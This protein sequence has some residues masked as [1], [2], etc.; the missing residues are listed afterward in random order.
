V[1]IFVFNFD[2]KPETGFHLSTAGGN[3][4]V[5][6]QGAS[7]NEALK[8]AMAHVAERHWKISGKATDAFEYNPELHGLHG[9][10]LK[11]CRQAQLS[12]I[13]MGVV[14]R[15]FDPNLGSPNN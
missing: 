12:G 3:A 6:C 9:E 11:L 4:T 10:G 14:A 7:L 8:R 1:K 2:V 15:G 13:A 5:Y